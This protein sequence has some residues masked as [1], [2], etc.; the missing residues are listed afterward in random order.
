[1][2]LLIADT[3]TETQMNAVKK[4]VLDKISKGLFADAYLKKSFAIFSSIV[5]SQTLLELLD[6]LQKAKDNQIYN[7]L[8]TCYKLMFR[9]GGEAK[10]IIGEDIKFI[11]FRP[12]SIK[13]LIRF[14]NK[15]PLR[16]ALKPAFHLWF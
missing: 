9:I 1:M 5:P 11:F 16:E 10:A 14:I 3:N 4:I 8:A 6:G 2:L 15:L 13:F 7:F 12:F